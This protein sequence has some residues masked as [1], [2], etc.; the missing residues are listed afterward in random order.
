MRGLISGLMVFALTSTGALTANGDTLSAA[1]ASA[2]A[3]TPAVSPGGTS[4]AAPA[5]AAARP[6][7]VLKMG[8]ADK[9]PLRPLYFAELIRANGLSGMKLG[10]GRGYGNW[11]GKGGSGATLDSIDECCKTHD[12]C[13]TEHN[14]EI[15]HKRFEFKTLFR[16]SEKQKRVDLCDQQVV[17]CWLT[18]RAADPARYGS[19]KMYKYPCALCAQNSIFPKTAAQKAQCNT[20]CKPAL[21][22]SKAASK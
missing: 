3:A 16:M 22:P 13:Y 4:G 14:A 17:R 18:A 6:G 5:A 1:E 21:F 19:G 11:C 7:I 10:V 2:R 20:V 8:K 9:M 15:F 12:E